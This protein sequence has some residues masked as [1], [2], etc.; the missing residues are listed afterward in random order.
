MYNTHPIGGAGQRVAVGREVAVKLGVREAEG[1]GTKSREP[2]MIL[3]MSRQFPTIRF[4]GDVWYVWARLSS[5]SP[6]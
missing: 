2:G 5:V 3:G 4:S 1:F 6:G